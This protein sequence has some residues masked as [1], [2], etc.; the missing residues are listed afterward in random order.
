MHIPDFVNGF[1]TLRL[2]HVDSRYRGGYDPFHSERGFCEKTEIILSS[3]GFFF[4]KTLSRGFTSAGATII[5]EERS[6]KGKWQWGYNE[7]DGA[8]LIL[9]FEDMRVLNIAVNYKEGKGL[10]LDGKRF[11]VEKSKITG[12]EALS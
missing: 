11:A 9:V 12:K 5:A 2:V 4:Y 3:E 6:E 8:H 7:Q 10:L 1:Q